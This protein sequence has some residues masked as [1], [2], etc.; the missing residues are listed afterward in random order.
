VT[1]TTK[2]TEEKKSE[3]QKNEKKLK[4]VDDKKVKPHTEDPKK[5][6]VEPVAQPDKK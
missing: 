4:P 2:A 5:T 1:K 6:K 3:D